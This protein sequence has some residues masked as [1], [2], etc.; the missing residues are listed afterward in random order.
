VSSGEEVSDVGPEFFQTRIGHKFYD[1]DVPR[2]AKAL[3]RIAAL[4]EKLV[5]G[6]TPVKCE[7]CGCYLNREEEKSEW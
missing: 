3:E 6:K 2:I 7:S 5:D 4:L 1:V